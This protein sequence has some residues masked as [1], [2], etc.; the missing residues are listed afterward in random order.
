V[1]Q[2]QLSQYSYSAPPVVRNGVVYASGS[3]SGGTLTAVNAAT[4]G[5]NWTASINNGDIDAPSVD[6]TGVYTSHDCDTA[7]YSLTGVRL[8]TIPSGCSGGGGKNATLDVA[9]HRLYVRNYGLNSSSFI[10]NT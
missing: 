1:W 9:N 6:D 7:K 10:A 8:W 4:G 5:I 3:G 2:Q